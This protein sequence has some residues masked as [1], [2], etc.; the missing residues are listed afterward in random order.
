MGHKMFRLGMLMIPRLHW[1]APHHCIQVMEFQDCLLILD[2]MHQSCICIQKLWHTALTYHLV[3]HKTCFSQ[4]GELEVNWKSSKMFIIYFKSNHIR[5]RYL[6]ISPLSC[7]IMTTMLSTYVLRNSNPLLIEEICQSLRIHTPEDLWVSCG[8]TFS[9]T[10]ACFVKDVV[11]YGE[12]GI[13]VCTH[14]AC[15]HWFHSYFLI[16]SVSGPEVTVREAVPCITTRA[17]L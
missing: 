14:S 8:G 3:H 6:C 1:A 5:V 7:I 4:V 16:I 15:E 10:I 2:R 9:H 13:Y 11:A 17:W 12:L